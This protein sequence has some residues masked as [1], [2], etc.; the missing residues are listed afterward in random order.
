VC[1]SAQANV[2]LIRFLTKKIKEL[3]TA[4]LGCMKVLPEFVKLKT[5]PGIGDILALTISLETGDI[6]RFP[7]VG[8]YSSY[9]R[10]VS[11]QRLSNEKKKGE[12]NRKNGNKY[13]GWAFVEAANF[14][15]RYCP[16]AKRFYLLDNSLLMGVPKLI[17]KIACYT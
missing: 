11:S 4:V 17:K 15:R 7:K 14:A 8:N 5:V 1:L 16:Y 10:C 12:N 3:E 6:R 13:L 9:C 2:S